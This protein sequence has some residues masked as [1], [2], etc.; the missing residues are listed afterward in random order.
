MIGNLIKMPAACE[1]LQRAKI[2]IGQGTSAYEEIG[3]KKA[4]K[5]TG[6]TG[7]TESDKN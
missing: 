5:R 4:E 6:P 1:A 3:I 2:S 7:S